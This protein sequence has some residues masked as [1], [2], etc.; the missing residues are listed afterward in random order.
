MPGQARRHPWRTLHARKGSLRQHT[1]PVSRPQRIRAVADR[2]LRPIRAGGSPSPRRPQPRAA[3]R[4]AP[5][6]SQPRLYS[7]GLR[8]GHKRQDRR[9][10]SSRRVGGVRRRRLARPQRRQGHL[11]ERDGEDRPWRRWR[12]RRRRVD[13]RRPESQLAGSAPSGLRERE[14]RW[15]MCMLPCRVRIFPDGAMDSAAGRKGHVPHRPWGRRSLQRRRGR[16]T[17]RCA[18]PLVKRRSSGGLEVEFR[19]HVSALAECL[20]EQPVGGGAVEEH[21]RPDWGQMGGS[22]K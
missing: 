17:G 14:R 10:R 2:R 1:L 8:G 16:L 20:L 19:H 4:R 5:T 6:P 9:A 7:W 11:P 12:R 15:R 13:L 3:C 22:S 18:G 21:D